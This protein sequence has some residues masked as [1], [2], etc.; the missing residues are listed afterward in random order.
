MKTK[1]NLKLNK[2]DKNILFLTPSIIGVF[3][4]F[5]IPYIDVIR[6]SF[7]N[8]F[9][10][11]FYGVVKYKEV[12]E[13]EAFKLAVKNTVRFVIIC[14]PLLL[15]LSFLIALFLF[16][17][18][19]I[20]KYLKSIFLIPMAVPVA[21]IVLLWKVVFADVGFLSHFVTI[22]GGTHKDWME[23]GYSFW[24]MVGSYIW[25]N[26]G[27]NIVLWIAGLSQIPNSIYEAS[28]IDGASKFQE[29]RYITLP[30]LKSSFFIITVISFINSFKVYREAYLIS[31][32]YPNEKI[33]MIQHI[34]N[35]WFRDLNVDK[36]SAAVVIMG[37]VLFVL[38]I[39]LRK[40][41][42]N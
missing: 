12:I 13:N 42:K 32:S 33:Y 24:I 15:V 2:S 3:V 38:V 17:N 30:N 10:G 41:W 5:V 36:M 9:T 8:T 37:V 7:F 19:K 28:R 14:I 20:G 31:G 27:Y 16:N 34:F 40:A 35:N 26:L 1:L 21:S 4:L 22:F 29:L 23:S 11:K 39:L 18:E 6:R 25:K